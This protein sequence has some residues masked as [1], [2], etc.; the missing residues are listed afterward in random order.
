MGREDVI[1]PDGECDGANRGRRGIDGRSVER[2][3]WTLVYCG[4]QSIGS[5]KPVPLCSWTRSK[6][7]PLSMSGGA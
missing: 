2:R 4:G 3:P 5:P 6:A 1:G 7:S